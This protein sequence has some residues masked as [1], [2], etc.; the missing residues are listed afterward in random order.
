VLWMEKF[1]DYV[2]IRIETDW[3]AR[4]AKLAK[5]YPG[6]EKVAPMWLGRKLLKEGIVREEKDRK[7][8]KK[9]SKA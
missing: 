7:R 4:L 6:E 8:G 1:D 5:S 3:N 2:Y 9:K